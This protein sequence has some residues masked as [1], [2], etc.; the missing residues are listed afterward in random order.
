[1]KKA[2]ITDAKNK[3]SSLVDL[4]RK[5]E[6]VIITDRDVPVAQLMPPSRLDDSDEQQILSKLESQGILTKAKKKSPIQE[7]ISS[8]VPKA[9]RGVDILDILLSERR[10]S[11]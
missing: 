2:S 11:P 3:F 7:I 4:V 6:T 5:G 9:K 1:M 8:P 10:D